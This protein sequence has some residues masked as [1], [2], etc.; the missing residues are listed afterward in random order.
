MGII[1][2]KE[3]CLAVFRLVLAVFLACSTMVTQGFGESS[4]RPIMRQI[5]GLEPFFEENRGQTLP[6][7]ISLK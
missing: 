6:E 7:V 5:S 1:S 2:T 4:T 3:S